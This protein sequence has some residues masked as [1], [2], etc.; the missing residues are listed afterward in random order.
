MAKI[1]LLGTDGHIPAHSSLSSGE[2]LQ[3]VGQNT[4][5]L[6][7]QAAV[8]RMIGDPTVT[9]ERCG[10]LPFDPQRVK[11]ACD[12]LV[13]PAANHIKVPFDYE[14]L[15]NFME[16]VDRPLVLLGLGAQAPSSNP[17][18]LNAF[19]HT[20]RNDKELQRFISV[21]KDR[22]IGVSV[23]GDFTQNVLSELGLDN[24]IV[25]GCPSNML[26]EA[27]IGDV[28]SE[29]SDLLRQHLLCSSHDLGVS[30]AAANPFAAQLDGILAV[31]QKIAAFAVK[32]FHAFIQQSGGDVVTDFSRQKWDAVPKESMAFFRNTLLPGGSDTSFLKN[33]AKSTHI[34][35]SF[36][37]WTEF[38]RRFDLC[39]GTRIHG[40]MVGMQ[41][42]LPTLLIAHD[43]RTTELGSVMRVPSLSSASFLGYDSVPSALLAQPRFDGKVFDANRAFLAKN[44]L[45]IFEKAEI[46]PT[47]HLK[48]IANVIS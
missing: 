13:F 6:V 26:G 47:A 39:I 27:R 33:V 3:L 35:F 1:A 38:I 7:F 40:C 11:N 17:D 5:N 14:L 36:D 34:F 28:I 31:E 18:D 24:T 19:L 23:R 12:V 22:A 32:H 45:T 10:D 29:N 4:G 42:G 21:L 44:F 8:I 2:L 25:T 20:A 9:V 48:K 30:V 37:A 46:T 43:S 41:A 16:A 15:T